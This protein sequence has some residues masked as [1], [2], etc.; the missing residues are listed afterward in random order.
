MHP[1]P[2]EPVL[3]GPWAALVCL[4]VVGFPGASTP[5]AAQEIGVFAVSARSDLPELAMARGAGLHARF[6]PARHLTLRATLHQQ[7]HAYDRR[8]LVCVQY[9]PATGCSE[10]EVHTHTRLRSFTASGQLRFRP[11]AWLELEAGPGL[12]LNRVVPSERTESGHASSLFFLRTM[13]FGGLVSGSA[14]VRPISAL[15][16]TLE[17]GASLHRL[18]LRA[19]P[20]REDRQIELH[21]PFCGDTSLRNMRVG[22]A[23]SRSW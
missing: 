11:V 19:C 2:S 21:L 13:Q 6:F 18:R 10:Q 4:A 14:R 16:V 1:H 22:L 9:F 3:R 5:A 12:S 23:Y 20:G 7:G 8:G 17:V 15:P